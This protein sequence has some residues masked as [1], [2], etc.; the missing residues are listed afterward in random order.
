MQYS[1][2]DNAINTRDETDANVDRRLRRSVS[3]DSH[4]NL[5]SERIVISRERTT[6]ESTADVENFD[7]PSDDDFDDI[8]FLVSEAAIVSKPIKDSSARSRGYNLRRSNRN[9][10]QKIE[11]TYELSDE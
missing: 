8:D 10:K 5:M 6:T 7:I 2:S 4:I 11:E 3:T 1:Q 9:R